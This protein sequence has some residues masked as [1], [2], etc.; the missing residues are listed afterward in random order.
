MV[1]KVVI[2]RGRLKPDIDNAD[3]VVASVPTLGRTGSERLDRYDPEAFK[4]ILIDEVSLS[5][6]IGRITLIL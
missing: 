3:V 2:D 1:Q 4:A 5:S 6:P